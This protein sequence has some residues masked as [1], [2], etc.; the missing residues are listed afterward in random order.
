MKF[1]KNAQLFLAKW[2]KKSIISFLKL[3]K[4]FA[5]FGHPLNV[6]G[7]TQS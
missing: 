5:W 4:R 2:G 1:L 7:S 6:N 3:P